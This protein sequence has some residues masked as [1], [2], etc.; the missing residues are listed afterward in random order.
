MKGTQSARKSKKVHPEDPSSSQSSR[1]VSTGQDINLVH[2]K[3]KRGSHEARKTKCILVYRKIPIISP[4]FIFVQTA[5][6]LGLFSEGLFIG[7]N[8]A[9]QNSSGLKISL[10]H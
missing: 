9:F 5:F 2:G 6:W 4:W 8:F 7:G 1:E 10:K 3:R